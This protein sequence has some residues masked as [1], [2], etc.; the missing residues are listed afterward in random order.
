MNQEA[1][2]PTIFGSIRAQ[3]PCLWVNPERTAAEEGGA[4]V[5]VDVDEAELRM[6]RAA[7]LLHR[8]WPES[9]SVHQAVTS[10]LVDVDR[11][12]HSLGSEP[13]LGR[14]LLK[15]DHQ[16]PVAGSVKARGGFHE[17]LAVAEGL[18]LS[19]GLMSPGGDL[20]VL[21]T[22][23]ARALFRDHSVVVGSTGNLGM[24]IGL[25][26]SALGF[27]S[28]VHMS[29]DAKEWKKK[30]LRDA[31][32]SVI[33]HSGDYLNAVARGRE[34]ARQDRHAHFVDDERSPDLF[35]GYAAAASEL[36]PQLEAHGV[37]VD[38]EHPLFVY[39][40]CGVG[41]APGGITFGLR[42]LFGPD[43]YCFFAEP[44]GA[45]CMVTQ[46]A[47]GRSEPFSIADIGLDGHT[48]ADGLAVGQASELVAPLMRSRVAGIYTL[49]DDQLF[50]LLRR[51]DDSE[52]FEIEPSAAA[53][54]AGPLILGHSR[55]GRAFLRGSGLARV[56]PAA[57]HVI[58][59]TGGAL[60]PAEERRAYLQHARQLHADL[61]FDDV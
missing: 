14:W 27:T 59:T 4:P 37:T 48:E 34:A 6:L 36:G 45:P 8:L 5:E 31:G 54:A 40:P 3:Q 13:E 19:N 38:S 20:L 51:L 58:W 24:A 23:P 52:G 28:I 46:M 39:L 30:R 57:T 44:V 55:T 11:L 29:R 21:A 10:P 53:G 47:S 12:S 16:L 35:S 26:S 18:A 49:T 2:L 61:R 33:E 25:L 42:R 56:M 1:D 15:A 17:V 22:E 32:V 41:G 50:T 9:V 43:V 7:P 60:I